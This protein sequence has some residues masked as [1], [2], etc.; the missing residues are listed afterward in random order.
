MEKR[1]GLRRR[2]RL[3]GAHIAL[4]SLAEARSA[5]RGARVVVKLDVTGAQAEVGHG[6]GHAAA[7]SEK[8]DGVEGLH[9]SVLRSIREGLQFTPRLSDAAAHTAATAYVAARRRRVLG[10]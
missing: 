6:D 9:R 5:Q 4:A 7:S 8:V 1:D 2:P 3:D 10:G